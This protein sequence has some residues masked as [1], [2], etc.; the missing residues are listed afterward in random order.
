MNIWQS[1]KHENKIPLNLPLVIPLCPHFT[2]GGMGGL[3]FVLLVFIFACLP[4][5]SYAASLNIPEKLVYDLTWTGIKAGTASL[6]LISD[7]DK[8]KIISTA[9][10]AKLIS[11][12]Y[13]VDDRVESTLIKNEKNPPKSPPSPFWKRDNPTESSHPPFWKRKNPPIPPLL[14]GGEGGLSGESLFVG[15]PLNYRLRIREGKHSK[16]KEVIFDPDNSR[17]TYIDHLKNVK[18]EFDVPEFSFDP[19]SGFYYLRTLR[20]EVG[21]P[22]YVTIFDSK[23]VWNVEV[24]VLRREKIT[25]PIGV[26]NTIVI[27]PLMKS[28]GIFYR[29]GDIIIWLTDDMK[30]IPV[31]VQTKVKIG[32]IT[33]TLVRVNY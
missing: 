7:E 30:R 14:K 17:A 3:L 28:E 26:F 18:K 31:M 20:L 9:C 1:K 21:K 22:V 8:I 4:F 32:H 27:K 19:L 23:K 6:E 12:F 29:E 10:S 24:Q 11:V 15:K 5:P 33:A 13:K 2:K 25:L 16:D